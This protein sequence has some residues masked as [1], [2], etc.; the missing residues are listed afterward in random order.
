MAYYK[1]CKNCAVDREACQTRARIKGAI[2]GHH[3]TSLNFVC[4]DRKPMFHCGQRIRFKWTAWG[5][6]DAYG[7]PEP[8]DLVFAGTVL[9]E[10]KLRFIIRVDDAPAISGDE[11]LDAKDVFRSER[12][13]V[14]VKPIDMTPT[15]EA[16]LEVCPACASYREEK[17]RCHGYGETNDVFSYW[18]S[19]C[20]HAPGRRVDE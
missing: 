7:E 9:S 14:K 15:G 18:P 8:M 16:D 6:P 13:V 5:D 11:L 3:V 2:A 19:G 10:H 4:R 20:F 17:S 12:L 1:P